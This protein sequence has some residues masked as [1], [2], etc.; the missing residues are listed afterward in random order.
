MD[1]EDKIKKVIKM[2]AEKCL[3]QYCK[4]DI[5]QMDRIGFI[6]IQKI[7]NYLKIYFS[8]PSN[9]ISNNLISI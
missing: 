2:G 5:Y 4:P 8:I 6:I 3:S 1:V 9:K 7:Q